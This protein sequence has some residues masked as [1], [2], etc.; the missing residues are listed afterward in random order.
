MSTGTITPFLDRFSDDPRIGPTHISL[1]ISILLMTE[2]NKEHPVLFKR[3]LVKK[4]KISHSTYHRC[5]WQ[6]HNYGYIK[7]EPSFDPLVGSTIKIK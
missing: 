6:L 1:F 5:I 3:D 2:G 7:Y 4:A